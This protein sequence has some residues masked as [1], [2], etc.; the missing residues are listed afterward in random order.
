MQDSPAAAQ[1]GTAPETPGYPQYGA[2]SAPAYDAPPPGYGTPAP[3]YDAG[4]G[5]PGGYDLPPGFGA[6]QQ[7]YGTPQGYGTPPGYGAPQGYGATPEFGA[8]QGYGASQEFG[9]PGYGQQAY[10][11]PQAYGQQGYGA[12]GYVPPNPYPP[13]PGQNWGAAGYYPGQAYYGA[14]Q[15]HPMA[16]MVLILG[17]LSIVL[18]QLIGPVAWVLGAKARREIQESNGALGGSGMVTAG[19]ICGIVATGIMIAAVVFFVVL[20]V[21]GAASS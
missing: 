15:D 13:A 10:G 6:G 12:P 8:P 5:T 1:S 16:I 17:V 9:Q 19:W 2:G 11:Q 7:P 18:C 4:T 3:G 20:A 21:I 14:R